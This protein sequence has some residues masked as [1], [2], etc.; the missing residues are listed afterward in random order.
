MHESK[1]LANG[2]LPGD[3]GMRSA[4]VH[5]VGIYLPHA[6]EGSLEAYGDGIASTHA[7]P[8]DASMS[9]AISVAGTSRKGARVSGANGLFSRIWRHYQPYSFTRLRVISV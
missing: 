3:F 7:S 6:H 2:I 9:N 5:T 8:R 4:Q 1:I